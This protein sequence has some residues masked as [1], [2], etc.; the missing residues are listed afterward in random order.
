MTEEYIDTLASLSVSLSDYICP[1]FFSSVVCSSVY[2]LSYCLSAYMNEIGIV[3][4]SITH[5]SSPKATTT[6]LIYR[7]IR[8]LKRGSRY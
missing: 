3:Y 5:K 1:L 2:L 4:T 8:Y 7:I 6:N